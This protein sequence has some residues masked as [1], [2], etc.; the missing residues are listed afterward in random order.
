M[1]PRFAAAALLALL[2][3]AARAQNESGIGVADNRGNFYSVTQ[4][5]GQTMYFQVTKLTLT[6]QVQWNVPYDPRVD[7]SPTALT[8]DGE[9]N[10]VVAGTIRQDKTKGILIVKLTS[11]GS[12]YWSQKRNSNGFAIPTVIATD[13]DGNIYAAAT[14]TEQTGSFLKVIRFNSAG[15]VYWDQNYRAGRTSYAR[16][17]VID[18]NGDAHVTVETYYGDP[19]T[20]NAQVRE[21]LFTVNGG[22]VPR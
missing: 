18:R 6:G 7:V 5:Y 1:R 11:A 16:S 21:V 8:V 20:E 15:S 2:P 9:G 4:R 12:V 19:R 17:M 3:Q 13:D 10:V 14:V 22:V